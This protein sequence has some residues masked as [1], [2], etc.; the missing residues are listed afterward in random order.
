MEKI[1]ILNSEDGF[2]LAE[3]VVAAGLL[4]MLSLGVMQLMKNQQ[5][6]FSY[7]EAKSE[8]IEIYNQIRILLMNKEACLN[9]LG[10]HAV[11]DSVSEVKNSS[12]ISAFKVGNIY[13]N[14]S[15]KI[16]SLEI[17][18]DTVPAGGGLGQAFLK[19]KLQRVKKSLSSNI[20]L[21]KMLLQV[22]TNATG[23]I[24]ECYSDT[25]QSILT[26]KQEMCAALNGTYDDTN[27]KCNLNCDPDS[28][29][30]ALST[31]C[32]EDVIKNRLDK[33]YVKVENAKCS[34]N[35]FLNGFNKDG[36]PICERINIYDELA[37]AH[38]YEVKKCY[39]SENATYTIK[40]SCP[41]GKRLI[42]CSGGPGD[43]MESGE[44]Y[45]ITPNYKAGTCTLSVTNPACNGNPKT[46]QKVI[47]SCY[48]V[49]K[50]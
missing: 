40:A 49:P 13:G 38:N 44:A 25:D 21:K 2:S 20:I 31:R 14:R 8:E 15:V 1:N 23:A 42:A 36:T 50:N 34:K 3:I 47:A 29:S 5:K 4:G 11:G 37:T 26:S 32:L 24:D 43:Q 16:V 41:S 27:G 7:A 12:N 35:E 18:N 33:R 30:A 48:D 6:S 19:I 46:Y 10:G 22:A 9:T 45:W 28:P 39:R 17:E